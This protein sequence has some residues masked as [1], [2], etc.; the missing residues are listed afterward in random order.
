VV[1][2]FKGL[3]LTAR[4][5]P[6]LLVRE[7][8][9]RL[10]GIGY[11][12]NGVEVGDGL[13]FR[14]LRDA[15][16]RGY[17]L[18]GCDSWLCLDRGWG[19]ISAPS[20]DLLLLDLG[21]DFDALY[22]ALD[23]RGAVVLDIGGYIGDTAVW[24]LA[25]GASYVHVYEPIYWRVAMENL[26]GKPAAVYPYAVWWDR[27]RLRVSVEDPTTGM[28]RGYIEVDTVPLA[29]ALETHRPNIVKM[30]CEGCEWAVLYTPC[31]LLKNASWV[32]EI[33]GPEP[34]ITEKLE[35]CGLSTRVVARQT[36][37]L[38]SVILAT[39]RH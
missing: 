31:E 9:R 3:V 38:V 34:P 11:R 22:G 27:R 8:L 39:P 33:H 10:L 20:P 18:W 14:L 28:H 13:T 2:L 25:R 16:L 19:V 26:R 32:I 23:Y 15:V 17:R 6:R 36:P 35:E 24:A 21:E 4:A 5:S 7:A 29:E 37:L 12:Y 1:G 30:D